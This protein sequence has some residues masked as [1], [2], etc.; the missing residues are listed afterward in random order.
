VIGPR[1]G[2]R[3]LFCAHCDVSDDHICLTGRHH[4]FQLG[5]GTGAEI[6]GPE[7]RIVARWAVACDRCFKASGNG[8][9][10]MR[11]MTVDYEWI[12]KTPQIDVLA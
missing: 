10:I 1:E 7:G 6:K 12:G 11:F 3:V 8:K 4:Y 2:E 5:D 9:Q